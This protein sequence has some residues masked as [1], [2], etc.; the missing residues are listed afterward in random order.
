MNHQPPDPRRRLLADLATSDQEQVA[1][2]LRAR[3]TEAMAHLHRD[4]WVALAARFRGADGQ[5]PAAIAWRCGYALHLQGR[6]V[7]ALTAFRSAATPTD[8]IDGAHLAAAHAASLWSRGEVESGALLADQ[9]LA[10]AEASGDAGALAAA[11][12]AQGLLQAVDDRHASAAADHKALRFAEEA[13]DPV[14]LARIHTH[15]ACADLEEARYTD[16]IDRFHAILLT[17]G[18]HGLVASQALA[19]VNLAETYLRVGRLDEAVHEAEVARQQFAVLDSPLV[20]AAWRVLGSVNTVRGSLGRAAHAQSEAVRYAEEHGF[21]QV[22]LPALVGLA[23]VRAADD[24]DAARALLERARAVPSATHHLA[25]RLAFGW[26]LLLESDERPEARA[27]ALAIADRELA[28]AQRYSENSVVAEALELAVLAGDRSPA[29]PRLQEAHGM[30]TSAGNVVR[31]SMNAYVA[32][33]LAGPRVAEEVALQQLHSLGIHADAWSVPG[34]L[35]AVRPADSRV[36][37]HCMGAFALE[38]DDRAV[39]ASAWPSRKARDALKALA[40]A[41]ADGL[42]RAHLEDLLWPEHLEPGNRLSV[43]LSQLRQVLDPGRVHPADHYVIS[44][45]ARVRLDTQHVIVDAQEFCQAARGVTSGAVAD[46]ALLEAVA[47]RYTGA[48]LEGEDAAW[49][50]APREEVDRLGREVN[51][52]LALALAGTADA[53]RAV[54]WL[55]RQINDDPYDEPTYVSLVRLLERLGRHGEARNFYTTYATR[56][57]ELDVPALAWGEVSERSAS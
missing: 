47:A 4:D 41:D 38:V 13:D 49:I 36:R 43:A 35:N 26:F 34:P 21:S 1:A 50:E 11:W 15:L 45:G 16:A 14:A 53:P 46:V 40:V 10:L 3:S 51:R 37:V 55:I 23:L 54:P 32:A 42:T 57:R 22:L 18:E 8:D 39:P 6:P 48:L 9:A 20:G 29:D 52:A 30:W 12:I 56:M 24:R 28:E 44:D 2:L 7:E 27:E 19:R 25:S 5:V 33:R 31:A 17:T